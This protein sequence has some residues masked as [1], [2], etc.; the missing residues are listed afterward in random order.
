MEPL[1]STNQVADANS[2]KMQKT[3]TV[4]SD[5]APRKM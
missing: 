4:E 3:S 5:T 2:A 1:V